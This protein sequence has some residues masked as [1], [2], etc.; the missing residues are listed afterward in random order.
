MAECTFF[1]AYGTSTVVSSD[2]FAAVADAMKGFGI[3]KKLFCTGIPTTLI[4]LS[5]LYNKVVGGA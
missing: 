5:R 1:L 4:T 3:L 2:G